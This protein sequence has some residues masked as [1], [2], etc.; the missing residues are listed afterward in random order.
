MPGIYTA[1]WA[2]T[3]SGR[4]FGLA[5]QK[6]WD[7]AG[8]S[9]AK[10]PY[11]AQFRCALA[12]AWPDGYDEMFEGSVAGTLVWPQR[13]REGHGYDPMFKPDGHT[14]TFA[15]MG[16]ALK[17]SISHRSAA[18]KQLIEGCFT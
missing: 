1:D 17:N 14:K 9:G 13:G 16:P 6:T 8:Q 5:M 10:P 2:E 11:R 12:L 18:L 15:E 7:L 3:L 4:D